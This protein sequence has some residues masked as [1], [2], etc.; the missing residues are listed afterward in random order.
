MARDNRTL[1]RFQLT[2]IPPAPRGVPQI[3]VT[4]DIDANGI[5]N[6]SA[7]DLGTGKEQ[8]IVIK[9]SSGLS[10]EEIERMKK[11]AEEH[12]EEDRRNREL[13]EEKNRAEQLVYTVRKTLKEHGD[14][15]SDDDRKKI[16]EACERCEKTRESSDDISEIRRAIE[17]VEQSMHALS[18]A[19]YEEAAK[20]QAASQQAEQTT[21][22]TEA[23]KDEEVIDADF[24][25]KDDDA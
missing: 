17:D 2:G 1:G 3:E 22:E 13:V 25:V 20:Q 23:K 9:S 10:R 14:K 11:E 7:K 18:Q 19:L 5:L 12:A 8:S 21:T 24:E 6:V 15:I 4:F 16:E